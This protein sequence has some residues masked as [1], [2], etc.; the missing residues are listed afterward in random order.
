MKIS[1][2]SDNRSSRG[3]LSEHGLSFHIIIDSGEKILF[4]TGAS[5]NYKKNAEKLRIDLNDLDFIV[6]SH[7]H[8]DHGNGLKYS[9][10]NRV[11]CHPD[12]FLKRYRKKDD[13]YIGLNV[14]SDYVSNN[15]NVDYREKPYRIT[16]SVFFLG[17]IPRRNL[18][19]AKKTL[20]YCD[21]YDDDFIYDDSALVIVSP[22]GLIVI[23][24]CAHSGVC[25]T[26][27]YAKIVTGIKKI[28][29]VIG[30][31]HLKEIDSVTLKTV[32]YFKENRIKKVYPCHCVGDGVIG[33]LQKSFPN[34]TIFSGS[35]LIL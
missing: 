19:E 17:Q 25:N 32:E 34:E 7:G 13:S 33:F 5:A 10:H 16:S 28:Y 35:I 2:L 1:V 14:S 12:C 29:A 31:F 8:W 18:F 20:F 26:V 4:D 21:G 6:L 3:F 24:G 23:T 11:I 22:M 15:F 27:E 30:G 9:S